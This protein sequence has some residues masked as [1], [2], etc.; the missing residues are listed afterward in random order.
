MVRISFFAAFFSVAVIAGSPQA[1]AAQET[2]TQSQTAQADTTQAPAPP[3]AVPAAEVV[4]R[5]EGAQARLRELRS[6]AEVDPDI[7]AVAEQLP[8]AMATRDELETDSASVDP[9]G[10]GRRALEGLRQRWEQY[11]SQLDSWQSTLI[12]RSQALGVDQDT[13]ARIQA[14]WEITAAAAAEEDYPDITAQT[15][16]S[17]RTTVGEVDAAIRERLNAVLTLQNQVAEL[18]GEAAEV[19]ARIDEAEGEARFGIF[20]PEQPPLWTAIAT[21]QPEQTWAT[22][23]DTIRRDLQTLQEFWRDSGDQAVVQF[24]IL[25][26]FLILLFV[27]GRRGKE[28]AEEDPAL[29]E[30]AWLLTRPFSATI[31]IFILTMRLFHERIPLAVVESARVLILIP[32]LRLLP[33]LLPPLLRRPLIAA[34]SGRVHRGLSQSAND[35]ERNRTLL[36]TGAAPGAFGSGCACGV[37]RRQRSGLC[38]HGQRA[39]DRHVDGGDRGRCHLRRCASPP[40]GRGTD[41]QI[42]CRAVHPFRTQ[43]H[44]ASHPARIGRDNVRRY[45]PVGR[46]D[47]RCFPSPA[48]HL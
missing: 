38:G 20:T 1:T 17:V 16:G 28:R 41:L 31:L 15:I 44:W 14:V 12:A 2:E 22:T 5:A 24:T 4:V 37:E 7:A 3:T 40:V 21:L 36:A 48:T 47:P 18:K 9:S 13:L 34:G 26:L 27:L 39:H 42:R 35:R 23:K 6:D 46:G 25:F 33:G 10:L 32:L 30:T 45:R 11:V 19:L 43:Q 29:K 8:V